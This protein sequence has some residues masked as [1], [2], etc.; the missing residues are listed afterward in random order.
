MV[1]NNIKTVFYTV[2]SLYESRVGSV[3]NFESIIKVLNKEYDYLEY[4]TMKDIYLDGYSNQINTSDTDDLKVAYFIGLNLSKYFED[5]DIEKK[6][7]SQLLMISIMDFILKASTGANLDTNIFSK[8]QKSIL[9]DNMEIEYGK[10]GVY[11]LFRSC[12]NITS[13]YDKEIKK[14]LFNS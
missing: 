5:N 14:S 12:Y 6:R 7:L 9:R 3:S 11:H 10:M 1:K 8:L 13:F 2:V 4:K